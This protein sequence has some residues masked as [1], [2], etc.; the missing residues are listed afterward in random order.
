LSQP[1]SKKAPTPS[2]IRQELYPNI[3]SLSKVCFPNFPNLIKLQTLVE[4][5]LLVILLH[6]LLH[7]HHLLHLIFILPDPSPNSS[8]FDKDQFHRLVIPVGNEDPNDVKIATTI[9]Q[10]GR[11]EVHKLTA[12][13]VS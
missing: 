2:Q 12:S 9:Y 3:I 6:L 10:G 8:N 1:A 7:P 13:E 4:S 11:K 5:V